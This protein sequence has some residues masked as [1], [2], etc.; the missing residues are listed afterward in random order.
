MLK[1]VPKWP[2]HIPSNRRKNR[3]KQ[4]LKKQKRPD[5]MIDSMKLIEN[6]IEVACVSRSSGP[7]DCQKWYNYSFPCTV[8]IPCCLL[9][10]RYQKE[11]LHKSWMLLFSCPFVAFFVVFSSIAL[12]YIKLT[13]PSCDQSNI[14]L[15]RFHHVFF[16]RIFPKCIERIYWP[17]PPPTHIP[18]CPL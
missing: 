7:C 17:M 4:T 2:F 11:M 14:A 13:H 5:W 15:L 16:L 8:Y 6:A 3:A 12:E 9:G 18:H 1:D 10:T